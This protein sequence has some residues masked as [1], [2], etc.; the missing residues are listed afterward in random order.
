MSSADR[1]ITTKRVAA[2]HMGPDE[3]GDEES[4]EREE[5]SERREPDAPGQMRIEIGATDLLD[6]R[7]VVLGEPALDLVEDPLLVIVQW[8][9][10]SPGDGGGP[11]RSDYREPPANGGRPAHESWSGPGR[12]T[13]PAWPRRA[14]TGAR[15]GPTCARHPPID[16]RRSS[17]SCS[18]PA[19]SRPLAWTPSS[20]IRR[21]PPGGPGR[22]PRPRGRGRRHVGRRAH[23]PGPGE[24]GEARQPC[25]QRDRPGPVAV[26]PQAR[27]H[28]SRQGEQLAQDLVVV[29]EVALERLL[30]AHGLRRLVGDHV[31]VVD[32]VRELAQVPG[33]R[34][35]EQPL[36][37]TDRHLRQ[38]AHGADRQTDAGGRRSS[39]RRPR[40]RPTGNGSRKSQR[41]PR[42]GHAA[43][44]R[45]CSR[46]RRASRR[47]SSAAT[48]TEQVTPTSAATS[49]RIFAAIVGRIAEQPGRAA[50]VE[51]G[52]V[53]RDRLDERRVGQQHLAE[54]VRVGP[55]RLEVR[56]R[57]RCPR[58]RAG[59]LAPP[60]SP[61]A[62]R[63]RA[64][65]TRRSRPHPA[66]PVPPTITGL[67]R[68]ATVPSAPRPPA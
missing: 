12:S 53:Q 32:P 65:R 25:L 5:E 67:P 51:E 4:E 27:G 36:Q 31:S 35:A 22:A 62:R 10:G 68:E 9:R 8:H 61:S 15:S 46:R 55:V 29:I 43:A 54:P 41:R 3:E 13:S 38:V 60:A 33:R 56:R 26:L 34:V 47:T 64:P 50:D 57:R 42:R 63:R 20:R 7:R 40:D 18:A 17:A 48:P 66:L 44:R 23:R 1:S 58:G 14:R 16:L 2:T 39:P 45:A 52:L 21:R 49:R 30:V 11:L 24:R 37:D 6:E 19:A 28:P 59:A